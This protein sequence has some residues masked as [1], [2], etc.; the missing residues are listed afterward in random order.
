MSRTFFRN[1][2]HLHSLPQRWG[3][4]DGADY[5]EADEMICTFIIN[6]ERAAANRVTSYFFDMSKY[7]QVSPGVK[8]EFSY[9]SPLDELIHD[10]QERFSGSEV[11]YKEDWIIDGVIK[12][13]IMID[14]A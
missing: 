3:Q 7:T 1:R 9:T 4:Y 10:F 14:W 13:G 8:A 6:L 11:T 2:Y 5:V 12:K